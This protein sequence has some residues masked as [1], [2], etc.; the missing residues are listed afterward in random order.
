MIFPTSD[1]IYGEITL[2]A[3]PAKEGY[4]FDG[5]YIV[6]GYTDKRVGG[7]GDKYVVTGTTDFYAVY[8]KNP[9]ESNGSN[10]STEK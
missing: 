4:T 2:P 6:D 8:T 10:S 7:K 5:W 9:T 1:T 3:A